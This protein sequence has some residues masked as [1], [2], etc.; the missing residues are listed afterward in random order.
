MLYRN[1]SNCSMILKNKG[2]IRS[3]NSKTATEIMSSSSASKC[4]N[5]I[6]SWKKKKLNKMNDDA[7]IIIT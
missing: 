1:C 3:I 5:T 7:L 6:E 2:N 4:D